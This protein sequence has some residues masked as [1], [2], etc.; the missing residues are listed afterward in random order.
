MDCQLTNQKEAVAFSPGHITGF[1]EVCDKPEDPLRTGSRGV[2]VCI[3]RGIMTRVHVKP[4]SKNL[5]EI[6]INSQ[7]TDSAIVSQEVVNIFRSLNDTQLDILVE[8]S[9]EIPIGCGLGASGAGA[10]SLALALNRIF[11][12]FKADIEA[13]QI[14]HAAEIKCKTGLGTVLAQTKGG[15]AVRKN[16]GGPGIGVVDSIPIGDDYRILCLVFEKIPTEQMLSDQK[17]KERINEKGSMALKEFLKQPKI[18]KFMELSRNFAESVGLISDR[19]RKIIINADNGGF[20]CSQA[21]F[22]ETVFSIVKTGDA[23][24]LAEIFNRFAPI[25]HWLINAKIDNLG[26]RV[27]LD[28]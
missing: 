5:I 8:H 15:F 25:P 17:L 9:V 16:P 12:V 24:K 3:N 7:K 20:V 14:A 28:K 21:M 4:S 1:F 2:G 22:G 23:P 18:E 26:A 11:G 13:A 27:L 6:Q 10:L 19:I